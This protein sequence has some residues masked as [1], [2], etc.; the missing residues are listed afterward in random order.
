MAD[1]TIEWGDSQPERRGWLGRLTAE[2]PADGATPKQRLNYPALVL[3]VLGFLGIVAAL[4]LPWIH[5]DL[6]TGTTV[7][8]DTINQ[9]ARRTYDVRFSSIYTYSALAYG[10]GVLLVLAGA[11][12]VLTVSAPALRRSL[13]AATLGVLGGQLALL[14]GLAG[15]APEGEGLNLPLDVS[16]LPAGA[17]SLGLGYLIA[18]AAIALLAASVLVAA[19]GTQSRRTNRAA[20]ESVTVDEP[21][22]L[23][24]TPLPGETVDI[25]SEHRQVG[26]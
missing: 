13:A 4:Y 26:G 16:N 7:G 12:T 2:P 1:D 24:V 11:A 9:A 22:D 21:I 5:V 10:L 23:V 18:I 3:T 6:G 20:I 17:V 14:V 8:Q 19:R 25:R 15:A